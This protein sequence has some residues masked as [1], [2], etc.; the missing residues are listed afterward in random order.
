MI[1]SLHERRLVLDEKRIYS[2][3]GSAKDAAS[4]DTFTITGVEATAE[5][6]K[7][8]RDT[9]DNGTEWFGPSVQTHQ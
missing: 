6:L 4:N 1:N 7:R 8:I 9:I 3:D 5:N 2:L